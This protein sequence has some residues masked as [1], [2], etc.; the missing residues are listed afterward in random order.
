MSVG[1][2]CSR[3]VS[4]AHPGEAV[5][6]AARRMAVHGVG[7]LVVIDGESRPL[8][9]L[10]DRDLVLRVL[11]H[12][13]DP[14]DTTVDAV[15]TPQ[16]TTIWEHA[17]IESALASMRAGRLRR[18]PVVDGAG[19]L[20]GIQS[21]DDALSLLAEE[22]TIIGGLLE[23]EAAERRRPR[24]GPSEAAFAPPS[25]PDW[26]R[27]APPPGIGGNLEE[28]FRRALVRR[29]RQRREEIFERVAETGADLDAL[30]DERESDI[31]EQGQ[32]EALTSL[33]AR[34]DERGRREVEALDQAL[35]R[36]G[37]A[38]YSRCRVCGRRIPYSRLQ[39]VPTTTLCVDCAAAEEGRS[40]RGG[41]G[42]LGE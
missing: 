20:V 14:R 23:G 41:E 21:L 26:D 15:M 34:L 9:I 13:L 2:I 39:A 37:E 32:E 5:E 7:T 17:P 28:R 38:G 35:E 6:A 1:R 8:G 16:P 22:L 40:A 31:V 10:T 19:R 3:E 27:A 24:P 33:L 25:R 30:A 12:G 36:L 11:A 4:I 29:L 42:G 18:L